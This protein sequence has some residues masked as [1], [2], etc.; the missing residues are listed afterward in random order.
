MTLSKTKL[1]IAVS[2]AAL[3]ERLC[4]KSVVADHVAI[5]VE[6]LEPMVK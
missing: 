4:T 1:Q 2:L 6:I 5:S 3:G